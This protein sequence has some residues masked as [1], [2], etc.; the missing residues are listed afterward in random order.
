VTTNYYEKDKLLVFKINEEIDEFSVKS[1]RRKADYEIERFMPRE[2]V[3]DFDSVKE[4]IHSLVPKKY[5]KDTFALMGQLNDNLKS[6]VQGTLLI[7]AILFVIQSIGLA[8]AG[9]KAPMVFGL[10]CALTDIIPYIGPYIGGIPAVLVGLSMSPT[11][12]IFVII[13]VIIS[14]SIENYFLQPVVMGKTMR[15]HPVTIMIGLLVFNHFFGIIGMVLATPT[16]SILKTIF[17]FYNDKYKFMDK[18]KD[19]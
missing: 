12:G 7:M 9:L 14:Q 3:F 16:I 10:F 19:Y 17:N 2:V 11:T 6:Y 1:I 15:L 13:A 8:I 4:H 5:K 18:I